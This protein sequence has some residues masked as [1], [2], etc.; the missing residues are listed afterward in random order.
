ML[1]TE[2]PSPRLLNP[3]VPKDLETICL[4]CLQKERARRYGSCQELSE[5]LGRYLR[6]VPIQARPIS[7][8][9][10][11]WRLCR[12]NPISSSAIALAIVALV[13]GFIS[14]T[15]AWIRACPMAGE[16]PILC[17]PPH[18]SFIKLLESLKQRLQRLAGA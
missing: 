14:T 3:N 15:A 10:R 16:I 4:K 12:R 17:T 8:V 9:A 13:G 6:G 11:F 2:P 5:E 1:E 7:Q 18:C